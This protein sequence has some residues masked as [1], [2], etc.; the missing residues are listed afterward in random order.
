MFFMNLAPISAV[1]TDWH[2]FGAPQNFSLPLGF[3]DSG[4]EFSAVQSAVNVNVQMIIE[5][6]QSTDSPCAMNNDPSSNAQTNIAAKRQSEGMLDG[7]AIRVLKGAAVEDLKTGYPPCA[8]GTEESSLGHCILDS[9]SDG[10]VDRDIEEAIQEYLKKRTEDLPLISKAVPDTPVPPA[11]RGIIKDSVANV[12]NGISCGREVVGPTKLELDFVNIVSLDAVGP[13]CSSPSSVSSNDSFELSIQAEIE[14]FLQDKRSKETGSSTSTSLPKSK[15]ASAGGTEQKENLVKVEQ[16]KRKRCV[17]SSTGNQT[18]LVKQPAMNAN[19]E[20]CS[21]KSNHLGKSGAVGSVDQGSD[22]KGN[23]TLTIRKKPQA[24]HR[25]KELYKSNNNQWSFST[26]FAEPR[27]TPIVTS[28]ELSDSSSDDGIEEAIQLY[29]L[30]QKKEKTKD[31]ALVLGLL[32]HKAPSNQKGADLHARSMEKETPEAPVSKKWIGCVPKPGEFR[33]L[34]LS[35]TDSSDQSSDDFVTQ[36]ETDTTDS[37]LG[38]KKTFQAETLSESSPKQEGPLATEAQPPS[39]RMIDGAPL[40]REERVGKNKATTECT[41]AVSKRVM[42]SSD[43][44]NS[45]AD[46]SD[47][48]EKEIQNY[49]ALKANQSSQKSDGVVTV[50]EL[51][52][53]LPQELKR[54]DSLNDCPSL[55]SSLSSSS[56]RT[57][58]PEKARLKDNACTDHQ[59]GMEKPR[60]SQPLE[61]SAAPV[62]LTG[63]VASKIKLK[64]GS[65]EQDIFDVRNVGCDQTVNRDEETSSPMD[66]IVEKLSCVKYTHDS[67]Q[68]DE[69]SSSLDSDEDLDTAT[70]DLLKTRKKLGKRSRDVKNRC[71]KRVRFTGAEVLTYSEQSVGIGDQTFRSP[72]ET[73]TASHGPL[74]S[75][76]SK[77]DK[78]ACRHYL[79]FKNKGNKKAGE[80]SES[81]SSSNVT[82]IGKPKVGLSRGAPSGTADGPTWKNVKGGD[83]SSPDSDDGIEQEILRFLAEKARVNSRLDKLTNEQNKVQ[84]LNK[85]GG[86]SGLLEMAAQDGALS[87]L[88]QQAEGSRGTNVKGTHHVRDEPAAG[89]FPGGIER[90]GTENK[91]DVRGKDSLQDVRGTCSAQRQ[92]ELRHIIEE[93]PAASKTETKAG[94]IQES[95]Q[96]GN[97]DC[98]GK[99]TGNCHSGW[100]SDILQDKEVN[101]TPNNGIGQ[102]VPGKWTTLAL[103]MKQPSIQEQSVQALDLRL[104]GAGQ[105]KLK[106]HQI[107]SSEKTGNKL[108][109]VSQTNPPGDNVSVGG[110]KGTCRGEEYFRD[111]QSDVG[112]STDQSSQAVVNTHSSL[113]WANSAKMKCE[114]GKNAGPPL[115]PLMPPVSL[116]SHSSEVSGF[117]SAARREQSDHNYQSGMR[118]EGREQSDAVHTH[119][120]CHPQHLFGMTGPSRCLPVAVP[121]MASTHKESIRIEQRGHNVAAE[122]TTETL[123][124]SREGDETLPASQCQ[125]QSQALSG[126]E[127]EEQSSRGTRSQEAAEGESPETFYDQASDH[128]GDDSRVDTDRSGLQR[129]GAE[130]IHLSSYIDPGLHIEPYIILSP[131]N[132]LFKRSAKS[133][134]RKSR[135]FQASF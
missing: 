72:E 113:G 55:F 127:L 105:H 32:P 100:H 50:S 122:S 14:R 109:G 134:Q 97:T 61:L 63:T 33:P 4:E 102:N 115:G 94:I 120:D 15:L 119:S 103:E 69:K 35:D 49:L 66:W 37:R 75:C 9:D 25:F 132:L 96:V 86:E 7:T 3:S 90:T 85:Q 71:K 81:E 23:E 84:G 56:P 8:L 110:G 47:S 112:C 59:L 68:T 82:R 95:W 30:E 126:A 87:T 43:S 57:P 1:Q 38:W 135:S 41:F 12:S 17:K 98:P 29:Q 93:S 60:E 70:K 67:W 21:T 106:A 118:S 54:E 28:G 24:R 53:T 77:S 114:E 45:S 131:E 123:C 13:K 133:S 36:R 125:P 121:V 48:I 39:D 88:S 6:L 124:T 73:L 107:R 111:H 34:N 74:K 89:Y 91:T 65:S 108:W 117:P 52:T 27:A 99:G 76:L 40:E 64:V 46:S 16:K 78:A 92:T 5:N 51:N 2:P 79:D 83:S 101:N 116:N 11:T 10:S 130:L 22:S 26:E 18:H 19:S 31:V 80:Q 44:E 128:S 42:S 20:V 129:Q 62:A 104:W 58:L